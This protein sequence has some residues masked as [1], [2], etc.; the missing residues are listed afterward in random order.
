MRC[1][2]SFYHIYI[3]INYLSVLQYT[4]AKDVL[5]RQFGWPDNFGKEAWYKQQDEMWKRILSQSLDGRRY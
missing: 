2:Y 3:Y 4:S 5:R 1:A